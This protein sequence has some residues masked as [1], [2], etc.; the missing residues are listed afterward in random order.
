[1]AGGE[2]Y[3]EKLRPPEVDECLIRGATMIKWDDDSTLGQKCVVKVDPAGHIIYWKAEDKLDTDLLE[4]T[5]VRDVRTA[6]W[7]RIPKD[8]RLRD[9]LNIGSDEDPLTEKAITIVHGANMVDLMYVTFV[10]SSSTMARQWTDSLV[11]ITH[12][13]LEINECPTTFLKKQYTKICVQTTQDGKVSVKNVIKYISSSSKEDRK[14]IQDA[15]QSVGLPHGKNDAISLEK[16]SFDIFWEF[17]NRLCN[18]QD[19][20][21]IFTEIGTKKKPYMVTEQ[22]VDFIN[23]NQ[24]DP[25]LNEILYP[26]CNEEKAR[27]IIRKYEPNQDF[28]KKGH[29]SVQG[30]TRYLMSEDNAPIHPDRLSLHQDMT[31]PI[32]HYFINSSHNTYLTGHQLTGKSSVEMYRQ[33]LLAGCRCIELDCWDGKTEDQEPVITHGMTLCT[34]ISFKDVIEAIAECAFKTSDYPVILSFE[35][36]CTPKQQLKMASY[37]VNIFGD[38]LL[39]K[40]LDDYPLEEGRPLPPLKVLM[41]KIVIKN[42]K[43]STKREEAIDSEPNATSDQAFSNNSAPPTPAT[44]D[45]PPEIN[46]EVDP[47]ASQRDSTVE[48]EAAPDM[49][50]SELVNYFQPVHFK[51]FD[52]SAKRNRSYEM[53]SFVETVATTQLKEKPVEFVNYNKRQLSRIYPKGTRVGSENYMP[54]IFWNAGCQLVAL[55]FQTLDLAMMLNLG[56]FEYNGRCGYILK[57]SFMRRSDRTFDPFAESTVDGIIA[58]AVHVKVISGQLLTEKK[59]GTYVEVEMYGLPADTVR[60]KYRTKVVPNNGINPVYDDDPFEFKKVVLPSLAVLRI[61]VYEESGKLIG[62]RIL[63]VDGL[64]PGYRHIKLRND[65][66]LP[67][68][69]P[70][71]FVHIITKDYVPSGFE[72]FANALCD[73][74]A[75]QSQEDKRQQQLAALLDEEDEP[76]NEESEVFED[77]FVGEIAKSPSASKLQSIPQEKENKKRQQSISQEKE[78]KKRQSIKKSSEP[79]ESLT[80]ESLSA[81]ILSQRRGSSFSQFVQDQM[82]SG[83]PPLQHQMSSP[84]PITGRTPS[85]P[86]PPP[87]EATALCKRTY[88]AKKREGKTR[89]MIVTSEQGRTHAEDESQWRHYYAKIEAMDL[90]QLREQKTYIKVTQKHQKENDLLVKKHEKEKDKLQKSHFLEQDKLFKEL[91]RVKTALR[92]RVDKDLKKSE[93]IGS[94]EEA[95]KKGM[96]EINVLNQEHNKMV[97]DLKRDHREQIITL[98]RRQLAEQFSLAKQQLEPQYEELDRVMILAHEDQI[99]Q[100]DELHTK[101]MNDLRKDQEKLNREEIK[102]LSRWHKDKNE[103]QRRKREQNKKHI[104]QAVKERQKMKDFQDKEKVQLQEDQEK[105]AEILIEDKE[106]AQKELQALF[107][108]KQGAISTTD[109]ETA[110]ANLFYGDKITRL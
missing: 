84:Y 27:E 21:K 1:M 39:S 47:D 88:S 101:Q 93:K 104:E 83:K 9:S 79:R 94:Y 66:N 23:N 90:D 105:I 87:P 95:Y 2:V 6:K 50:L 31:Q 24:R 92:K 13:L 25:R 71:L 86:A 103:L 11:K 57:P 106:R 77:G 40:P 36:H 98:L 62:Q 19:I 75:F 26:Y 102:A 32:S 17:Y 80:P 69:L 34:E 22:L 61:A 35:N 54:Q 100:M 65:C 42:K 28:V 91:D 14:R 46:G 16:F 8:Q 67:L 52:V 29:F 7:A 37:C 55:N 12:N 81:N 56:I 49:A 85:L 60:K 30:L 89:S 15:L 53:S 74:I 4:L 58:G 97:D 82:N 41:R 73:P 78:G 109:L 107:D 68:T 20:D 59:V 45:K 110:H 3:F 51:S 72:D 76:E 99:K 33:T 96:D 108:A 10:S 43:R 18:R 48:E 63:P 64:N 38:M 5:Y 70:V 44:E